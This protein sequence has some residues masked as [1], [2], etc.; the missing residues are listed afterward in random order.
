M[1]VYF[2]GSKYEGC[3]YVRC[4]LPLRHNGWDGDFLTLHGQRKDPNTA[5]RAM[6]DADIIVAQRPYESVM[7]DVYSALKE[8]G[9]KIVF[10]N[11]DTY[12]VNDQMKLG[13]YLDKISDNI[14]KF[15]RMSDMVTTT[16]EFLAEEYRKLNKNVVVIPNQIDPDDYDR[17]LR[18]KTDKI[19]IGVV[20]SVGSTGD[21]EGIRETLKQISDDPRYQLVLFS[22]PPK[23]SNIAD[24][25][26]KE[27]AFWSSLNI[28]WQPFVP[29]KHYFKTLNELRLDMILIPREDSYFN[30]GKSNLK[31]LE[32]SMFEI[33]VIAQGFKTGDS[34]YQLGDDPKYMEIV[35][36][37]DWMDRVEKLSDKEVRKEIGKRAKK[38]VLKNY[39]ITKNY[40]LWKTAYETLR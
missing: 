23:A 12:K 13:K 21:F 32:A 18:N 27:F 40:K 8:A 10:D 1:K 7:F 38:Y 28:E 15:I 20:G 35:T 22:L 2:L 26:D 19:R 34:P 16:T 17:P 11:D 4:M 3:Y 31:F 5:M 36:E 14:D 24:K 39:N 37:N 29:M 30:R 25:Y 9:K 33:P 6:L